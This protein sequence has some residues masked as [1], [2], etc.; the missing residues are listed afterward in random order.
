MGT[1]QQF[2]YNLHVLYNLCIIYIYNQVSIFLLNQRTEFLVTAHRYFAESLPL[3]QFLQR[4]QVGHSAVVL[5]SVL[6]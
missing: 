5:V 6:T 1:I 4:A 2:G 3:S